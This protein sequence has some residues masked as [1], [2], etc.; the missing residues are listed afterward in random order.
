MDREHLAQRIETLR[1]KGRV[2]P[3]EIER[4]EQ[5]LR[6]EQWPALMKRLTA[7]EVESRFASWRPI[8]R[9]AM[10]SSLIS[11]AILI[12]LAIWVAQHPEVMKTR[13]AG[14]TPHERQHAGD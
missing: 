11:A 6:A 9:L 12:A 2:S 5:L 14:D 10:M 3:A 13:Q 8:V 1:E 4:L 7:L